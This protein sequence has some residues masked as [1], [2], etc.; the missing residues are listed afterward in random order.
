MN[1]KQVWKSLEEGAEYLRCSKSYLR[2]M[3]RE[4]KIQFT[5]LNKDKPLRSRIL[6]HISWLDKFLLED[7]S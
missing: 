2:Q 1:D 6:F 5:R 7:E 4:K 3:V